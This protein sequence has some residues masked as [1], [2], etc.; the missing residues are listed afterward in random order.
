LLGVDTMGRPVM[1]LM[2]W[3]D[4][5]AYDAAIELRTQMD[6]K[7][8]HDRVGARFHA[9]YW[10]AKL[11][12]LAKNQPE[13]FAHAAQWLSFGEYLH[14]K[15]LDNSVCSLSMASGT[16]MLVTRE[17]K[18]DSELMQVCGVRKEQM[19]RL[20]DV[21]DSLHGLTSEYAERWPQ[22]RDVPWFPAIGD[23]AAACIGSGCA[24]SENW[25]LTMGTSSA[26]RVVVAPD[27]VVPPMG[28]WL[29][30]V[31]GK[32]AVLGGALSE[33]GNLLSWLANTLK[34]PALK[35]AEPLVEQ[36]EPDGHGL[37]ILPFIS[38]ERSLGWHAEARMT[39]AG[40]S[41]HTVPAELL[42]A[43][44]EALAY[45]INA[46]YEQ[47]CKVLQV[48]RSKPRVLGSGAALLS[49]TVVR[50]IIADTLGAAIYPSRNLE[51]SARGAA[52]LALEA[53]GIIADVAQVAPALEEPTQ[54]NA[55][56]GAIYRKAAERQRELYRL[57]LPK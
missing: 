16:G 35:D 24:N 53:L 32:R 28:L 54:P 50:S 14:R 11:R 7:A 20:G 48:D 29:Y 19:P 43:G 26:V 9:S 39:V 31:D 30:L 44:I 33:G 57:L 52:L 37:T 21:R 13:T 55:E 17:G 12:W 47:L 15:F 3:E 36:L 45:R 34:L 2:T 38:G 42:R 23:G 6:E 40:I 8:V 22:L 4:T 25:S 51:A 41:I 5:R 10:P 46:V 27:Q 18:W 56:H 49:S 1:P